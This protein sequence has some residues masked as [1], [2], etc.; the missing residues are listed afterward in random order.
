MGAIRMGAKKGTVDGV[1]VGRPP[2]N[3]WEIV[4]SKPKSRI[5]AGLEPHVGSED[6]ASADR[7]GDYNRKA[8][9]VNLKAASE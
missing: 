8:V 7:F 3:P 5:R 2:R 6:G 4:K 1:R 9:R